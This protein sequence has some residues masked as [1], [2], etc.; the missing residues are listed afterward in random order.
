M[1]NQNNI[2]VFR[3]LDLGEI[4]TIK[5]NNEPW[6][7]AKDVCNILGIKNTTQATNKLDEDERTILNIGR[8]GNTNIIN[9]NGL[10][11]LILSSRKPEAKNSRSYSSHK[12]NWRL[13][14]RR[15]KYDR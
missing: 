6:F 3:Y 5:I 12:T 14:C 1:N 11:T 9:E 2:Q 13:Y 8:Q 4:R 10:Y 7:V 15:R